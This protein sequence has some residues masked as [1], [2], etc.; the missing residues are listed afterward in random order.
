MT[1]PLYG[2]VA[3]LVALTIVV[4]AIALAR[5]VG[6]IRARRIHPQSLARAKD[7][8]QALHDSQAMDNFNNLLQVPP[9]F[10]VLCLAL[11]QTGESSLFYLAG[12]WAYVALRA[13][14]SAIQVTYNRVMHR[15]YVWVLG[16]LVL[17][18]LWGAFAA[19]LVRTAA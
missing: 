19:S 3:A 15:F 18:A 12:A 7:T 2:P 14:H 1:S 10:Y 13:L 16:N 6:E 8:A 4:W 11:A 9:L 5:R 17:F